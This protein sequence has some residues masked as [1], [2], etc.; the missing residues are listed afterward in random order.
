[1][2]KP[3]DILGSR[4]K[5]TPVVTSGYCPVVGGVGTGNLR[6]LSG[7]L[8]QDEGGQRGGTQG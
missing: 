8:G 6:L 4:D 2:T 5:Q 3:V 7:V 1:M